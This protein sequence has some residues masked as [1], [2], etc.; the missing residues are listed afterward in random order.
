MAGLPILPVRHDQED[1]LAKAI[2]TSEQ[3]KAKEEGFLSQRHLTLVIFARSFAQWPALINNQH[4][5][6]DTERI[7]GMTEATT[8]GE[9]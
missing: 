4:P 1:G 2:E 3:A 6:H 7:P 8:P 5:C 9:T